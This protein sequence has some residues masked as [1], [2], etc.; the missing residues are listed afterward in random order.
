MSYGG[1]PMKKM[2]LGL[3]A[4]VSVGVFAACLGDGDIKQSCL[5]LCTK[6][7]ECKE[8]ATASKLEN[9]KSACGLA[10]LLGGAVP[11]ACKDAGTAFNECQIA[12]SCDDFN[13]GTSCV[14]EKTASDAACKTTTK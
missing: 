8:P 12:L 2:M 9:C 11:D 7:E 6:A 14:S 1:L 13:A 10:D 3:A 4:M 5:D